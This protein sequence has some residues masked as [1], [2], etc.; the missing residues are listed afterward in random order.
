MNDG[1]ALLDAVCETP[2]D[3]TPRLVYADWLEENGEADRA[4]FIRGQIELLR[5]G[6][7]DRARL[8][9]LAARTQELEKK[10]LKTWKR[11]LPRWARLNYDFVVGDLM[12]RPD[13]LPDS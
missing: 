12:C 8:P 2:D 3:D 5:L 13:H 10:H 11:V 9:A 7:D 4:E 1:Q 6:P